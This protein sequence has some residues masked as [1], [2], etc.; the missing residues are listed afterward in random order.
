MKNTKR[1]FSAILVLVMIVACML[2]VT[3]CKK[4]NGSDDDKNHEHTYSN[5][6]TAPTCTEQGYTT[7][8]CECG[9]SY[10]DNYTDPTGHN[11]TTEIMKYPSVTENGYKKT[12][13]S[14]CGSSTVEE[15]DAFTVV[16]PDVS[17]KLAAMIATGTY[18]LSAKEGSNIA[19]IR[20][21][22]DYT[23][24]T[25]EKVFI[26]FNLA[27]AQ[28]SS[29]GT[30]AKGFIKLEIGTATKVI[31]GSVPS[32]EITMPT[33]FDSAVAIEFYLNGN[34]I[35]VS[36]TLDG[37]TETETTTVNE[38]FYQAL[39]EMLGMDY[40][41]LVETLYMSNKVEELL[42]M[43]FKLMAGLENI[44][45]PTI[46]PEAFTGLVNALAIVGDNFFEMTTDA[47][48]N[49]VYTLNVASLKEIANALNASQTLGEFVDKLYGA[50]TTN[51]ITLFVSSIPDLTVMDLANS[52]ASYADLAGVNI[53]EVYDLLDL[54]IYLSS[55]VEINI[56]AELQ[57]N[58][59][60]TIGDIIAEDELAYNP[61]ANRAEIIA[62]FKNSLNEAVYTIFSTSLDEILNS[63]FGFSTEYSFTENLNMIV[64]ML[65]DA[66]ALKIVAD[67]EGNIIALQTKIDEIYIDVEVK[68]DSTVI[69]MYDDYDSMWTITV[70]DDGIV[71]SL[72]TEG[73]EIANFT[74]SGE[75]TMNGDILTEIYNILFVT[76][77]DKML[78]GSLTVEDGIFKLLDLIAY[79]YSYDNSTENNDEMN[80]ATAPISEP[81]LTVTETKIKV[82]YTTE[83]EDIH[84]VTIT[85]NEIDV[86]LTLGMN[87]D[88]CGASINV[89]E[90]GKYICTIGAHYYS[91]A[92]GENTIEYADV[93]IMDS[94]VVLLNATLTLENG[95]FQKLTFEAN[96]Y[97]SDDIIGGVMDE[98]VAAGGTEAP[99]ED[100]AVPVAEELPEEEKKVINLAKFDIEYRY[101]ES[102]MRYSYVLTNGDYK[103]AFTISKDPNHK[104]Y[105]F[106]ITEKEVLIVYTDMGYY[107]ASTNEETGEII[108]DY[109][110]FRIMHEENILFHSGIGYDRSINAI[111]AELEINNYEYIY[112]EGEEA[113]E[114]EYTEPEKVLNS[115]IYT[116]IKFQN[117]DGVKSIMFI[118]RDVL[119]AQ[120]AIKNTEKEIGAG[121]KIEYKG[122]NYFT[123]TVTVED[124]TEGEGP[125][126]EVISA[127][128]T[129]FE[130]VLV[131][132]DLTFVDV[133][134]ISGNVI[135]NGY[136]EAYNGYVDVDT[137]ESYTEVVTE[138]A[139]RLD[140][141]ITREGDVITVCNKLNG[142]S[143]KIDVLENGIAINIE[144]AKIIITRDEKTETDSFTGNT[145]TTNKL[146]V[147]A[148]DG[149]I[150]MLD[151]SLTSVNDVIT[152]LDV[153]VQ[154]Y[155]TYTNEE[156]GLDEK[157][158]YTGLDFT[159][160]DA[161]ADYIP[162]NVKV[163]TQGYSYADFDE[164]TG[165]SVYGPKPIAHDVCNFE[166]TDKGDDVYEV[167]IDGET[168]T[169]AVLENGIKLD[170][171][172]DEGD[173]FTATLTETENGLALNAT[174]GTNTYKGEFSIINTETTSQIVIMLTANDDT[175][176]HYTYAVTSTSD[177]FEVC[178][179]HEI[180]G[181]VMGDWSYGLY[182]V[183]NG[184]KFTYDV[185]RFKLPDMFASADKTIGEYPTPDYGFGDTGSTNYPIE[186]PLVDFEGENENTE[187]SEYVYNFTFTGTPEGTVKGDVIYVNSLEYDAEKDMYYYII[188]ET[189]EKVYV[190]TA[191]IVP[192][193]EIYDTVYIPNE[194]YF[195]EGEGEFTFT[196]TPAN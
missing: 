125:V 45:M 188:E 167:I 80:G 178:Y 3:S 95:K 171:S 38:I 54:I 110:Y 189:G 96:G 16:L 93:L 36:L 35:S 153:F 106:E 68:A 23:N 168:F 11:Y 86:I 172:S 76:D 129:Y 102:I 160:T 83:D 75:T 12:T 143:M 43:A 97:E 169:I 134:L 156:T 88:D 62:D 29:D 190:L 157:M 122:E 18:T 100:P 77:G 159:Y 144:D 32:S 114:Y 25:G 196:F 155:V 2:A 8:T 175:L 161:D 42:G 149:E 173:S 72:I 84:K 140:M 7:Y 193:D 177:L 148:L 113:P 90:N 22:D 105:A 20:E 162:E 164:V 74:I 132:V 61:D 9:D 127:D 131:D 182:L 151:A 15:I 13:C 163:L 107:V 174:D 34:D 186:G 91:K 142:A 27:D 33:V 53:S 128:V 39:A 138:L 71:A 147:K 187:N 73:E 81:S 1:I 139:T 117:L 119:D 26:A 66:T 123:A 60:K 48:G 192:G 146:T 141:D 40:E 185:N 59:N 78:E 133:K 17:E 65:D 195:I 126:T 6:V 92:D 10:K 104:G 64:D 49:S 115:V 31:D 56:Q 170:A 183:D 85:V 108:F 184:I 124:I 70:T 41:T 137:G 181:T 87:P 158:Y 98:N 118:I 94:E 194:T 89:M 21:L 154:D 179:Y 111:I 112:S 116:G 103:A 58:F 67:A 28:L 152:K 63:Y 135:I 136:E 176:Y 130:D 109:Y 69:K 99:K 50:G 47:N 166:Y 4:D 5:K 101:D 180:N 30:V 55:G 150:V 24:E 19:L 46:N 120:F 82:T 165:E 191:T 44:E 51:S 14:N 52:V 79:S 57:K 37:I 145:T 121:V